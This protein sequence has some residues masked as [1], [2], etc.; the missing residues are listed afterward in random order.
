MQLLEDPR[1]EAEV[2]RHLRNPRG[3][4]HNHLLAMVAEHEDGEFH[5]LV[6]EFC[7]FG[8]FFDF[9]QGRGAIPEERSRKYFMQL[10][11]ALDYMHESGYCHLDMSLEN[12]LMFS[13]DDL[14]ICDFG[15]SR[16]LE[17]EGIF[18]ACGSNMPGK[19]SYRAPEI[20]ARKPFSGRSCDIFSLGVM[21]FMMLTGL[22]P[23][24]RTDDTDPR[25]KYV[26]EGRLGDLVVRWNL[27][28]KVP[29]VVLDL[30]KQM[31]CPPQL[32]ISLANI[33]KHPWLRR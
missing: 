7:R 26:Y 3:E 25:F 16:R 4:S 24:E 31:M 5:Y 13:E 32:R 21:L 22:P 19:V 28:N 20:Q 27:Q 30:L 18:P 12:V 33:K 10:V 6:S 1:F 17:G 23:F 8:E 15:M 14:K 9:V 29:E 11:D 2:M